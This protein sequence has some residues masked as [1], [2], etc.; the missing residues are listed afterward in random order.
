MENT[1]IKKIVRTKNLSININNKTKPI[2]VVISYISMEFPLTEI[3]SQL[4]FLAA[5][6]ETSSAY[7]DMLQ[8]LDIVSTEY[9][10]KGC[11]NILVS[12]T[13]SK[14]K[15]N[16]LLK[17]NTV[18]DEYFSTYIKETLLNN[19]LDLKTFNQESIISTEI[20][21]KKPAKFIMPIDILE[22]KELSSKLKKVYPQLKLQ[23][24]QLTFRF[25]LK[26][27]NTDIESFNNL[28]VVKNIIPFN[29]PAY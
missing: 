14:E 25:I 29:P 22:F 3:L 2:N 27:S 13:A 16:F 7:E 28:V 15:F 19:T 18:K 20:N 4:E 21:S 26:S 11:L 23:E 6:K 10:F 24:I 12:R 9:P 1:L 5:S 17:S 8:I